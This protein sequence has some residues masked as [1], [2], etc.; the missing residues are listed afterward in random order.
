M[1]RWLCHTPLI[2]AAEMG[3]R[4]PQH[5]A[6]EMNGGGS[7]WK[8]RAISLSSG[9]VLVMAQFG[10]LVELMDQGILNEV[11]EWHGCS[12]GSIAALFGALGVS[13]G[14]IR[15]FVSI[16]NLG[17]IGAPQ[18]ACIVDYTQHWG[19]TDGVA[20]IEFF[21]KALDT[22]HPGSSAWTFADF[23]AARPGITL[24]VIATN[25]SRGCQTRFCVTDTPHVRLVDAVRAS[26]TVPLYFTPWVDASG[27]LHCDGAVI[28]YYPWSYLT[29]KDNT[30]V[31]ACCADSFRYAARITSVADYIGAIMNCMRQRPEKPRNWIAINRPD[32]ALLDFGMSKADKLALF[33][34]G[35][36]GARRW[37]AWRARCT[38]LVLTDSEK[39]TA[40]TLTQ[41]DRPDTL[42]SDQPSPD[43]MW[44]SHQS[45]SPQPTAYPSQDSRSDRPRISRRWSL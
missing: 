4:H 40:Q 41:C 37:V 22:W 20:A 12:C 5:A 27:D 36:A 31:I 2:A 38:S 16:L 39:A 19:V 15:D 7:G 6:E 35:I 44:D 24:T 34:D 10:I 13:A 33:E 18:D 42:S 26:C 30:L 21:Q 23:A 11:T 45:G 29:D 1:W 8:P 9:G 3:W 28:E 17:I 32:I 25:V 14:W 43:R